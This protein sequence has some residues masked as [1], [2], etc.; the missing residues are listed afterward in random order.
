[1]AVS[2]TAL[3]VTAVKGTRLRSVDSIHLSRAGARGNRRFYLVDARG[4][5]V[6]SKVVGSLQTVVADWSEGSG[7]LALSFPDGERVA[8]VVADGPRVTSRFYRAERRDQ[9]AEGPWSEAL[10]RFLG[11]PVRLLQA[12]S[13][14]DRGAIGAAS[15]ISR[16]SLARLAEEA[17]EP[18]VDARRFRMLIEVDGLSAHEED[19]WV[20]RSV[21]IGE[22]VVGFKGHVGR[23]LITSRDPDTGV[24][25]LPTLDLLGD[26]RS[27][28][29]STEPLPFGIYG[30]VLSEGAVRVG[31][32][33]AIV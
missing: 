5:M 12:R 14:V 33:V 10:S 2:V 9:L 30:E 21:A 29:D 13:A 7:E 22:A 6:N 26:Y 16:G 25:D 28:V 20:G 27:D 31:D 24:I 15:L 8:G 19:G 17:S 3:S 11:Q 23:C 1:L 4:R 18:A 32:L